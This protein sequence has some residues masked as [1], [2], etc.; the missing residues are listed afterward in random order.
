MS[1]KCIEVDVSQ[2][3]DFFLKMQKA[4][5]S[6]EL[7]KAMSEWV[8]SVGLEFLRI[9][10]DEIIRREVVD[11][12]QLLASFY[13][14]DESGVWSLSDGGLTLEVG[15]TVEYAAWVNDG[16]WTIDASNGGSYI[17]S[18]GV[19]ARFVPGYWQGK[20]F[21]YDPDAKGGMVLKQQWVEGKHYFDSA[22]HIIEKMLPGLLEAKLEK[23]LNEYFGM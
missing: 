7:K 6:G 10:Q 15:S 22:V 17:I 14:D 12:R 9:V 2:A 20:H 1:D 23:W 16:H 18:G 8:E 3:R 21:V 13:K 4:G 5:R 19:L 11:T